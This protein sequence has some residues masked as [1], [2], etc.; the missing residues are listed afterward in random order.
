M[1]LMNETLGWALAATVAGLALLSLGATASLQ[2]EQGPVPRSAAA[3]VSSAQGPATPGPG[4]SAAFLADAYFRVA[5]EAPGLVPEDDAWYVRHELAVKGIA[6]QRG[7][8][9]LPEEPSSHKLNPAE[10]P[11]FRQAGRLVEHWRT[12]LEA[13]HPCPAGLT[14]LTAQ[15]QV[16]YDWWLFLAEAGAAPKSLEIARS[17][18][19]DAR[20]QLTAAAAQSK[21]AA[22]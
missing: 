16:Q 6:A 8:D 3:P 11:E 22:L 2:R 1:A 7:E 5:R 17:L 9:P 14:A 10:E 4:D 13:A 18:Y 19:E 12:R 15:L 20:A 21:M